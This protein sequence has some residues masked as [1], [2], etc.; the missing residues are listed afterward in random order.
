MMVQV[1]FFFC[2]GCLLGLYW[3]LFY[4]FINKC[5]MKGKEW[6]PSKLLLLLWCCPA[7]SVPEKGWGWGSSDK[8]QLSATSLPQPLILGLGA[9][10]G[11]LLPPSTQAEGVF[12]CCFLV[13]QP[14]Q[15]WPSATSCFGGAD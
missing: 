5:L 7:D 15:A 2:F 12:L 6:T 4:G 13:S 10:T 9:P 3:V 1:A 14:L 8:G 11:Q